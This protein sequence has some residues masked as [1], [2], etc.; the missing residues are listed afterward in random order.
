MSNRVNIKSQ[1]QKEENFKC[2]YIKEKKKEKKYI[3]FGIKQFISTSLN[4][5]FIEKNQI[6]WTEKW[7]ESE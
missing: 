7:V 1:K 4:V 5:I 6:T 2:W 3:R